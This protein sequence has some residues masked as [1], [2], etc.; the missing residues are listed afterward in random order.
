M[1]KLY[2]EV[3]KRGLKFIEDVVEKAISKTESS[4][5]KN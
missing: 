3:H 2:F 5:L 4:Y 1:N